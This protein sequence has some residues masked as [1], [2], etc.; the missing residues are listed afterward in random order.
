MSQDTKP[1]LKK[2]PKA[3]KGRPSIYSPELA[4]EICTRI[5]SG[6]SLRTVCSAEDMPATAT[7]FRWLLDEKLKNFKDQYARAC[8]ERSEAFIEEILDIADDG[9]NDFIE[10]DY[11]KGKTPGYQLN[12]ENIQR[13]RLRV[14][15]RK[16][17]A[18]KL[19]P[20][21]YGDKLDVTSKDEKLDGLVIIKTDDTPRE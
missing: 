17:Y 6:K 20:K 15:T 9:S 10:D 18:S 8:E 13:S 21:K 2:L 3:S 5:A 16:W 4:T 11:Q 1:E 19:K 14:D 12:Q 7:V